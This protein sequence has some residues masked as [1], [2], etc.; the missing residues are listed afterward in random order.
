MKRLKSPVT[1]LTVVIL[2]ILGIIAF[3]ILQQKDMSKEKTSQ[4]HIP[5]QGRIIF[6]TASDILTP[7]NSYMLTWTGVQGNNVAIFL[8]DR[9]LEPQGASVSIVDRVY[10]VK[11]TG[12]YRYLVPTNLKAGTYKFQIGDLT[13]KYFNIDSSAVTGT[14]DLISFCELDDLQPQIMLEPA[15]GNIYGK[16]TIENISKEKCRILGENFPILDFGS[17]VVSNVKVIQHGKSEASSYLL[18]PGQVVYSQVHFPNGPQCS[19]VKTIQVSFD[20]KFSPTQ[21][22][23]FKNTGRVDDTMNICEKQDETTDV[24]I[25]NI[26]P[27]PI[28]P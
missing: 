25:W 16:L 9:S 19:K 7:G 23:T 6:P 22:L 28:T 12:S 8:I 5:T 21:M 14:N 3:Y 17:Q 20:Y 26:S 4:S 18:N 11:N 2:L 15:A 1:I 24:D 27:S 10:D 13:G